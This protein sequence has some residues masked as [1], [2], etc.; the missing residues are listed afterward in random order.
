MILG[1]S[2][3]GDAIIEFLAKVSLRAT[4][5]RIAL[6]I[7]LDLW[8]GFIFNDARIEITLTIAIGHIV[9]FAS[10]GGVLGNYEELGSADWPTVTKAKVEPMGAWYIFVE[11]ILMLVE[12]DDEAT[13]DL[14]T[15]LT[16]VLGRKGSLQNI[17]LYIVPESYGGKFVATVGLSVLKAI[18]AGKLKLKLG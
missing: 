9:Y 16:E 7:V 18:N 6:E 3:S 17:P 12:T 13:P 2:F 8:L 1:Q 4:C 5:I 15:L 14:V 10:K 11:D